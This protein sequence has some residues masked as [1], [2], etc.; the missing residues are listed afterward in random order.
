MKL[1]S[2]RMEYEF[3]DESGYGFRVVAVKDSEFGWSASV[4]MTAHGYISPEAAINHL[5]HA[6]EAF[7]RQLRESG[8]GEK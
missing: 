8:M 6:A 2:T 1:T 4:D 5:H 7:L 3:S